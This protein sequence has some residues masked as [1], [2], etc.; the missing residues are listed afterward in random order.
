MEYTVLVI[1]L[2]LLQYIFF[3]IQCAGARGKSG[4]EAPATVGD[5]A[6]E[7]KFRIQ[8]NTL[9]QIVVFIPAIFAFSYYVSPMWAQVIGVI[10]IIGRFIYSYGYTKD[11]SKRGP[12]M[13]LTMV[14]NV[15][16]VAGTIIGVLMN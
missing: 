9:E 13:L 8:C 7:R 3:I 6:Y 2:A 16:L 1:S 11:P 14:P 15:V 4:L 10:W 5:E 12:G